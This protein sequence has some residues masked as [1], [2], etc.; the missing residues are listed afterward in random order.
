MILPAVKENIM[1][2]YNNSKA[3]AQ[4]VQNAPEEK[5]QTRTVSVRCEFSYS[6]YQTESWS[7]VRYK[8][9]EGN[10]FIGCGKQ[11]PCAKN[12]EY[13]LYGEWKFNEKYGKQLYVS[14][15]EEILP[16]SKLGFVSYMKSLKCGIGRSK[17]LKIY[18]RFGEDSWDVLETAPERVAEIP[19]ISQKNVLKIQN[20]LAQSHL[21][22]DVMKL[23]QGEIEI[24][25]SKANA[26][27][28]KFGRQT[29]FVIKEHTY[30]LC[31]VSGF[32]FPLVDKM[33][34]S[35]GKSPASPER[36]IAAIPYVFDLQAAF[37]N[38]CVPYKEYIAMLA[39]TLNTGHNVPQEMIIQ[40]L[41][42]QIKGG[43]V[44]YC[45]G[46]LYSRNRY[47]EE[48]TSVENL[49]R[50]IQSKTAVRPAD[51]DKTI[52]EF[53]QESKLILADNQKQAVRMVFANQ[54]SI[55]TG[56]PGTGKTTIIKAIL[57]VSE[58]LKKGAEKTL[59]LA[60]TAKAARRMVEQSGH[61]ASTVHSALSFTGKEDITEYVNPE[62]KNERNLD[63]DIIIV[64]EV[65]MLDQF[66]FSALLSQ[67]KDR[68]RVVFVGDPDQLPS[69]GAGEV[70]YQ[71]IRSGKIPVTKLS[72]IY[73]QT[74]ENPIVHNALSINQGKTDLIYDPNSFLL[75]ERNHPEETLKAAEQLYYQ[76]IRNVGIENVIL[77]CPIRRKTVNHP[78]LN[79]KTLNKD[80]QEV[81]NPHREGDL[82]F[83]CEDTYFR[84]GDKVIQTKNTEWAKNGDTG[85][86]TSVFYQ[87]DKDDAENKT[88]MMK[89]RFDGGEIV[90]YNEE[91]ARD[92]DLAYA[93]SVHK[94]QGS[95]YHTVIF[96]CDRTHERFLR[97]NLIYTATT[98][99]KEKVLIV[100]QKETLNKA[101]VNSDITH[102]CTLLGDRAYARFAA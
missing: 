51:V 20:A 67:V 48:T 50:L 73:R 89:I 3:P 21:L 16:T 62:K 34:M 64:D 68:A 60:P 82:Q 97:R 88:L 12:T 17:A 76:E 77:L 75:Y 42:D 22:R 98:R 61:E 31:F 87:V 70:L 102:R 5:E 66:I 85:I 23:F 28:E 15:Y 33:A 11:I 36:I 94:S 39:R 6:I 91:K 92:L 37:G 63:A 52:T 7:I 59:L 53:E 49:A 84:K 44:Y 56:G 38:V 10:Y 14:F 69:V 71:M 27:I 100:G 83:R 81:L 29:M 54:V 95:E 26:L 86:V 32:S 30:R 13:N 47:M 24:T 8:D 1:L 80:I 78:I 72:V 35:L 65:S 41:K 2:R 74:G 96:I 101:V 58:K 18:S 99:A 25:A 4:P 40:V 90:D 93:M 79:V 43:A 55:I 45:S 46:Y 57:F 9:E 19:G